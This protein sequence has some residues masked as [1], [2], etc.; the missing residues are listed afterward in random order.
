MMNYSFSEIEK[1]HLENNTFVCVEWQELIWRI[2]LVGADGTSYR[3]SIE[4]DIPRFM[5][6]RGFVVSGKAATLQDIPNE[7]WRIFRDW[8]DRVERDNSDDID[9]YAGDPG[10]FDGV[11]RAIDAYHSIL[12]IHIYKSCT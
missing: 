5:R 2:T 6:E 12:W 3:V 4:G 10:G 8:Q 7:M 9:R 11:K 1:Q